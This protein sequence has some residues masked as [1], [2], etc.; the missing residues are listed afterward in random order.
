MPVVGLSAVYRKFR[1]ENFPESYDTNANWKGLRE[2]NIRKALIDNPFQ[3][4]L[5]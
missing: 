5:Q 1:A 2:R 4:G 3:P